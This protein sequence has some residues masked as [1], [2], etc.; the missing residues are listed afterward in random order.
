MGV[1]K[2]ED[3]N[4]GSTI[5]R[6]GPMFKSGSMKEC[7]FVYVFPVSFRCGSPSPPTHIR[8]SDQSLLSSQS[9]VN[10]RPSPL[11]NN[12]S[13]ITHVRWRAPRWVKRIIVY[14]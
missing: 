10:S 8:I 3:F 9:D 7:A 11:E 14:V 1:G 6:R 4:Q 12:Q 13:A 5:T 2:E